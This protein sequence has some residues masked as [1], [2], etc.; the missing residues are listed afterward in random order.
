[1]GF[2]ARIGRI[3]ALLA[4]FTVVLLVPLAAAAQTDDEAA[5]L[6]RQGADVYSAQCAG[7]HQAGGVGIAG[8]FPPL[9]DNPR[10]QDTGYVTDVIRNGRQGPLEVAGV[11]YDGVMPAFPVLGDDELGALIAYIQGGFVL[12]AGAEEAAGPELPIATGTLPELSGMAIV[13]AFAIAA[14]AGLFV[15]GPRLISPSNRLTMP[16]LDATLRSIGIVLY[17]VV[18]TAVLPS[19]VMKT[20]TVSRLDRLVQDLIGSALWF[21]A[22]VVGLGAL[23]WAHRE[24]RI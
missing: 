4:A 16:W 2:R 5:D 11:Q 24:N 12:P 13:A 7:C 22:L 6:I 14:A 8:S 21:G 9:L 1:M 15:L 20:E 3:M 10:I 18:G 19:M 17:L 23:W